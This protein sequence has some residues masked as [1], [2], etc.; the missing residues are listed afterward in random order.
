MKKDFAMHANGC[1]RKNLN[2]DLRQKTLLNLLEGIKKNKK[3]NYDCL[4]PVS[5]GKDGTYVAYQ[6]RDKH[7]LNIL[8]ATTRPP[9]ELEVGKE[10]LKKFY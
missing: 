3:G 6:L 7:K 8:T 10:N 5:G 1:K 2:W 4:V 9:I